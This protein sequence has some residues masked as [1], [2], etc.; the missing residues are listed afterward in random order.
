MDNFR[1]GNIAYQNQGTNTNQHNQQGNNNKNRN[2]KKKNKQNQQNNQNIPLSPSKQVINHYNDYGGSM[3]LDHQSFGRPYNN[4]Y[5]N[6]Q[7][8]NNQNNY[9]NNQNNRNIKFNQNNNGKFV[10]RR[11]GSQGNYYSNGNYENDRLNKSLTPNNSFGENSKIQTSISMDNFDLVSSLNNQKRSPISN[12][13]SFMS[14]N[15]IIGQQK[16]TSPY[17]NGTYQQQQTIIEQVNLEEEITET[18][19]AS[20]SLQEVEAK[21]NDILSSITSTESLNTSGDFMVDDTPLS[22]YSTPMNHQSDSSRLVDPDMSPKKHREHE[23]S[24][25]NEKT[26]V[27]YDESE[28]T[29]KHSVENRSDDSSNVSDSSPES[30]NSD[31]N[32]VTA[33]EGES[34]FGHENTVMHHHEHNLAKELEEIAHSFDLNV[35]KN[36][37]DNDVMNVSN[38]SVDGSNSSSTESFSTTSNEVERQSDDEKQIVDDTKN[39]EEIQLP[40]EQTIQQYEEEEKIAEEQKIEVVQEEEKIV[41]EQKTVVVQEEQ[42]SF[43]EQIVEVVQEE[44]I[45][46]EQKVEVVQEEEEQVED[47]NIQQLEIENVEIVQAEITEEQKVEIVQEESPKDQMEEKI[48]IIE[49]VQG[50]LKSETVQ[51]EVKEEQ[52]EI[53]EQKP[54]KI[55][56][57]ETISE[58]LTE[59]TEQLEVREI[60]EES[61]EKLENFEQNEII[62]P[63]QYEIRIRPQIEEINLADDDLVIVENDVKIDEDLKIDPV[64]TEVKQEDKV[65]DEKNEKKVDDLNQTLDSIASE[66]NVTKP[67]TSAIAQK[68]PVVDC[69]SCTIV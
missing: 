23:D 58:H 54:E 28:H 39:S 66:L 64:E 15:I 26:P 61:T 46:E 47:K 6:N 55:E 25:H 8:Y 34:S 10:K 42:N 4:K 63:T 40:V 1:N 22:C 30:K 41:E 50:E 33:S 31:Q 49:E 24:H 65:D 37:N 35:Q 19:S 7:N 9:Q 69:F 13:Y 52:N 14:S 56:I 53:V 16:P 43:N 17:K 45:V 27:K 5:Q 67:N 18:P 29:V 62:L 21:S 12:S 32:L 57:V 59:P 60:V 3:S 20:L 11:N 36:E 2:K 44:K 48:E 68:E 38:K 51:T